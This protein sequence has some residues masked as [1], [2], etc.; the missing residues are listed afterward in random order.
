MYCYNSERHLKTKEKMMEKKDRLPA[1]ALLLIASI[2]FGIVDLV[3]RGFS[4][5]L[6]ITSLLLIALCFVL[7]KKEKGNVLVVV[8]G[9]CPLWYLVK[10][11]IVGV[12]NLYVVFELI[13]LFYVFVFS[14]Q[15]IIKADMTK[16]KAVVSKILFIPV[17]LGVYLV[18]D[19]TLGFIDLLEYQISVV[20]LSSILYYIAIINLISWLNPYKKEKNESAEISDGEG[21]IGLGKHIA[22]LLLTF[23]IWMLVWIY[24]TTKFLN[25]APNSEYR[26]P[27]NQLLL[28]IFVPFY[29]IYWIYNSAQRIDALSKTKDESSE[30]ISQT[31]LT[32]GL[33]APIIAFVFMQGKINIACSD[34]KAKEESGEIEVG[35]GFV[36]IG[37]HIALLILTCGIWMLIWIYRTTK[38][39]NS[40]PNEEKCNPVNQLLLC[41]F[42]PFYMIYWTYKS[43]QKIDVL[44]KAKDEK[45]EGIAQNSLILG[46][47]A[48]FAAYIMM[49]E[50]INNICAK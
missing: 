48:P 37:K 27:T 28:C 9:L 33:V 15:T 29:L 17:V 41:M 5:Y 49:Q 13:S 7:F 16:I 34:P 22:L 23:G 44:S 50:K 21:F 3:L 32:L 11:L 19:T 31:C 47:L 14:E 36:G 24:R 1:A 18:I 6:L 20:S 8:F 35:D 40:A 46:T 25:K 30:T 45:S 42:V 43:A 38:F 26:N 2:I 10:M 12:L 39:L 4:I